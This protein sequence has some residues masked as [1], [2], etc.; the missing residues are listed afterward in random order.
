MVRALAAPFA[1]VALLSSVAFAQAAPPKR[2]VSTNLCT[3]EYGFRLLPRDRIAA[4]SSM[5]GDTHPLVSTIAHRVGGI[6]LLHVSAEAVLALH[7]DLVV[8]FQ[9]AN[10]R[11]KAHLMEAGVP[12]VEMPPANSLDDIRKV[13]LMLGRRFGT[14]DRAK[15]L[16]SQMDAKLAAARAH[17]VDPPVTA[18][19]YEPNGYATSDSV[20]DAIMAASGLKDVAP[21][22]PVTRMGRI[23]IEAVIAAAPRLLILNASREGGPALADIAVRHPALRALKGRSL[24]VH[25]SLVPLLCAGPWSADAAEDFV[26]L[27]HEAADLAKKRAGH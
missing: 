21:A 9:G 2:V 8:L 14:E 10:P 11:L 17:A 25:A 12:I 20:D 16:I 22:M 26:R 13:T 18:L 5:A 7:P 4:L 1:F 23:P 6:N 24:I 15:D 3:D 27:G 19:I